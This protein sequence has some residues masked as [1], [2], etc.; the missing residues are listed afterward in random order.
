MPYEP[1]VDD[2]L[3]AS[4]NEIAA[5]LAQLSDPRTSLRIVRSAVL[6]VH[7]GAVPKNE[8]RKRAAEPH[9]DV[10]SSV[11]SRLDCTCG[12]CRRCRDNSRWTR[13]F[14]E[15]FADPTYYDSIRIKHNSSLAG[16][17]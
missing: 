11:K 13:V 3:L 9:S 6:E 2:C 17:G 14:N 15:K 16:G 7:V 1:G 4:P 8:V 12:H 5:L 10:S